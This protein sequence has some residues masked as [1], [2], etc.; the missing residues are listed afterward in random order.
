MPLQCSEDNA[1]NT[2]LQ[3]QEIILNDLE[4]LQKR[5]S[6][7]SIKAGISKE[8][9]LQNKKVVKKVDTKKSV[10]ILFK[11][12]HFSHCIA[13]R[14]LCYAPTFKCYIFSSDTGLC[15]L[16]QMAKTERFWL[17]TE[18]LEITTLSFHDS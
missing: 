1:V 14:V 9:S 17:C 7:L 11:L 13:Y 3:R 10:R 16:L 15:K 2:L 18:M 12:Q 4:K 6:D 8:D 5:V